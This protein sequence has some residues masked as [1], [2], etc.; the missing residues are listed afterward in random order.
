MLIGGLWLLTFHTSCSCKQD[1]NNA[2]EQFSRC[3]D[4]AAKLKTPDPL[5]AISLIDSA[6]ILLSEN[7]LPDSLV[8]DYLNLKS[9]ALLQLDRK[10]S[11]IRFMQMYVSSTPDKKNKSSKINALLWLT[12]FS[13]NDGKYTD[14]HAYLDEAY[15]IMA[16][17]TGSFGLARALNLEGGLLSRTGDCVGA[18]KKMLAAAEIFENLNNNRA[19]G[20]VYCGIANNY[21]SLGED[22]PALL[23]FRKAL[24]INQQNKDSLNWLIA[25]NSLGNFYQLTNP[26]SAKYYFFKASDLMSLKQWSAESLSVQYNL[27][28]FYYNRKEYPKAMH[29]YRKILDLCR[30]YNI[31]SGIYRAMSGIGNVYEAQNKDAEALQTFQEAAQLAAAAGEKPVEVQLLEGEKYMHEKAGNYKDAYI[32]QKTIKH[33]SDSLFALDKQI[34]VHDLELAY[35]N[36]KTERKNEALNAKMLLM[37]GR[38]RASLIILGLV[39]I[40]TLALGGLLYYLYKLYRQRNEAYNSLFEKYRNDIQSKGIESELISATELVPQIKAPNGDDNYRKVVE[41][42]E[43]AKPFLKADLH[44]DD[45]TVQLRMSRKI[46][47]QSIQENAGMNLK[48][49]INSYRIKEALRLLAEPDKQ[50]YKIEAIA[51]EAG[52]GS[53][54]GFYATFSQLTGSRPSEYR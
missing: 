54:A 2:P 17:D 27:A 53:K 29:E 11:A 39:L 8:T 7:D 5:A 49:F 16:N 20:P 6:Y 21:Q 46:L 4:K 19:L 18:Q 44:F 43:T 32:T 42:F 35:N 15:S 10:D 13:I 14:S 25:L 34:A 50:N 41:Y 24:L 1:T 3:L 23:Y 40:S 31:K 52:F 47:V 33:L 45:L 48:T 28:M 12:K 37:K 38:I 26:D 22:G 9:E 30:K 51:K 36:E